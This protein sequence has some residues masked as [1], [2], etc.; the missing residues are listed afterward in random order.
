MA[1]TTAARRG[2]SK[3]STPLG[4]LASWMAAALAAA[5][6]SLVVVPPAG[7]AASADEEMSKER[8]G[9]YFLKSACAGKEKA[10]RFSR[11]VFGPD[12][13]VS[14]AE[15]R[16]RLPEFKRAAG[17]VAPAV[18][19]YGRALLNPPKAWPSN[20]A[21]PVNTLAKNILRSSKLFDAASTAVTARGYYDRLAE[22]SRLSRNS[23]A[24]LVRARLDLPPPGRGC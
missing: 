5:L 22:L 4:L 3:R 24:R 13:Q 21:K 19:R 1:A 8:A 10:D 9:K 12:N 16:R 17:D 2:R 15:I 6:L 7:A 23:P 14:F 18:Y 11:I 20:V